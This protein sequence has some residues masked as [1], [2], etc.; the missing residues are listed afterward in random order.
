VD[1]GSLEVLLGQGLSVE[2]IGRRFGKHPSTVAYWMARHGLVANGRDKHAAKGGIERE[3]LE[4]LVEAG[5]TIAEIA[6]AVD[7]CKATVRHWLKRYELRTLPSQRIELSRMA[8]QGGL[9]T[10][11]LD[12][13]QH[14]ESAHVLCED[15]TYRCKRCRS[16]SVS[17]RR[18]RSKELLV[19]EAGGRCAICGYDRCMRALAFHHIDR[20]TKR[21][22]LSQNGVTLSLERLRAEARKCVLLCANC[23]AEVE[24]GLTAVPGTVSP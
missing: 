14:G 11:T 18:R 13:R 12:C 10:I 17:R 4:A 9:A 8:K 21:L 2:Q 24:T 3:R 16:E 6:R 19:T 15:G 22:T 5:M 7:R 1:K 23:H 20:A